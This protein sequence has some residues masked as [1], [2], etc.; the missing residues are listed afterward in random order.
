M[1]APKLNCS[2]DFLVSKSR[3][4]AMGI[5]LIFI[6]KY[7]LLLRP[8]QYQKMVPWPLQGGD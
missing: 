8:V 7:T 2:C 1:P 3:F 4:Y 5:A 6:E